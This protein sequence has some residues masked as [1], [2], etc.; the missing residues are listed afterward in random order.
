MSQEKELNNIIFEM[1]CTPK[2]VFYGLFLAE[3]NRMF[4][5]TFPTAGVGKHP[6]S[7]VINMVIGR[8]FWD[9]DLKNKSQRKFIIIHELVWAPYTAMYM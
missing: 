6:D 3:V 8:D 1:L 2:Y 7:S 5:D 9:K 4:H